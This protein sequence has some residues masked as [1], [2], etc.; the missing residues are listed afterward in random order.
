METK[1]RIVRNRNNNYDHLTMEVLHAPKHSSYLRHIGSI[2]WQG[3]IK[4]N[5]Y[6]LRI[7]M[8][9]EIDSNKDLME[10]YK[11]S[12]YIKDRVV[13]RSPQE[14]MAIIGGVEY[15]YR[16]GRFISIKDHGKQVYEVR[17]TKESSLYTRVIAIN[18]VMAERILEGMVKRNELPF[19]TYVYIATGERLDFTP[20][21]LEFA[22]NRDS[23]K[24]Q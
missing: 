10:M 15:F 20:T 8:E 17:K 3:D 12:C 14:V 13:D 18:D 4:N 23:T 6:A 1:I 9:T 24:L 7:T 19:P 22:T 5:W 11:L 16:V 2:T 21:Q